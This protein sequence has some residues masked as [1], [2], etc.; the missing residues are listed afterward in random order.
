[1]VIAT[2]R[3]YKVQVSIDHTYFGDV[4]FSWTLKDYKLQEIE[5][6]TW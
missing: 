4:N 1:M 5:A 6:L 3:D 2:D